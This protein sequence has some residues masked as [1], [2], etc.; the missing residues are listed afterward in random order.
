M[1]PRNRTGPVIGRR[2]RD[3]SY[4]AEA[5]FKLQ[6]NENIAIIPGA[7]VILNPEHNEANDDIYVGTIQT[8]FTF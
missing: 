4:H 2:D 8:L 1:P 6:L 7:F 5:Y 3:T